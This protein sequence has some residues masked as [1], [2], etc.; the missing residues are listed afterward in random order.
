MQGKKPEDRVYTD[1]C[2]NCVTVFEYQ[3]KEAK[4]VP[5]QRDGDFLSIDCPVCGHNVTRNV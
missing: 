4:F 5:D 1:Q 2:N 3:R